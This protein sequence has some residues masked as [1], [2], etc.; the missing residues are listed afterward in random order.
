[1]SV[2]DDDI[3]L[4]LFQRPLRRLLNINLHNVRF[5]GVCDELRERGCQYSR[6]DGVH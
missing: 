6:L 5:R 2:Y 4:K 1:L 3:P